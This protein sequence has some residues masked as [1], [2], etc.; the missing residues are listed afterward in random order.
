[1]APATLKFSSKLH[2][3]FDTFNIGKAI[4]QQH[5]EQSCS[6]QDTLSHYMLQAALSTVEQLHTSD[7][8]FIFI[9]YKN[10]SL[11][12]CKGVEMSQ[13]NWEVY[14]D[15]FT[16]LGHCAAADS[17]CPLSGDM[18]TQQKTRVMIHY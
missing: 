3:I 1:M 9:G 18:S 17:S 14:T 4:E 11:C 15:S 5:F 2:S 16:L 12:G 7:H 13:S 10:G 6:M 8:C